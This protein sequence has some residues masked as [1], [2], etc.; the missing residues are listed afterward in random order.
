MVKNLP[1]LQ[2]I[3]LLILIIIGNGLLSFS[4]KAE[5]KNYNQDP[6]KRITVSFNKISLKNAFDEIAKKASVIIIY[7]NSKEITNAVVSISVKNKPI[8][9]VLNELLAPF[10]LSYKVIDDKFVISHDSSKFKSPPSDIKYNLEIPVKGKVVDEQ[11]KPLPGASVKIKQSNNGVVTDKE[12]NF[13]ISNVPESGTLIISFVGYLTSE[14]NYVYDQNGPLTIQLKANAN[15]LN[16]VQVIGYGTTT[17]RLNTGSVST[18]T[19]KEIDEQPVTNVLSALSG[20]MAGVFVQQTN[21]LPGGG[22]SILIRGKGSIAAGTDPLYIIDG[23]PFSSSIIASNNILASGING[24]VSPLNSLNPDDIESISILKDADATAIYGSRGSNGVVLITTKKGKPGK[25]TVNFNITNGI[26]QI[27]NLPVLLNSNQYLQIRQEAYKNDGITPSSDPNDPNYAPDLKVWDTTKS[28]DWRKYLLGRTGHVTDAQGTIS[29][30]NLN[31]NFV[32]GGNFH[33]ETSV[34]PGDN[35]YERGGI[36][37]GLQHT[38]ENHKFY[39]Q[40]STSYNSDKNQLSNITTN[41]T[42]DLLLPP[43]FPLYDATGNYNYYLGWNPLAD[44][45]AIS[46]TNT[47]NLIINSL[48]KYTLAPGLDLK[49]SVGYNKIG[50]NQVMTYPTNSQY[51]GSTNFTNFGN[52]SNENIII[53]P[54][55]EYNKRFGKSLLDLLVGGTYQSSVKESEF[56]QASNFSSDLLLDNISSATTFAISNY[57]IDYKY[58]S[59]FARANYNLDEKYIINLSIRR[60]GSSRF[61]PGNEFGNFGAIGAAWIF[62]S[63]DWFKNTLPFISYGKLRGSYGITGN[64][65]ITDYQYLSTYG[66]S[67]F[68]YQGVAGIQPSRIA[69]AN[70]HWETTKKLEFAVELGFLKDR[71]LLNVNRYQNRTNDQLVS[72]SIPYLTG[73]NTY[74]ANLPAVVENSGW[75]FEVNTKNFNNN[76]FSW[77]TTFNLTIPKNELLSFQNLATSSYANTLVIGEPITRIYGYKFTG[78]DQTGIPLFQTQSNGVSSNPS[79]ATDQFFTLGKGYPN[80]YGGIGNTFTYNKWTLNIFGQF[81]RQFGMGGLTYTPGILTNNFAII[82]NR[83]QNPGDQTNIPKSSN[84]YDYYSAYSLSSANFFNTSYF[85]IKNISLSYSLPSEWLKKN[86]IQQLKIYLQG[87]NLFTFWNKKIPI[88]DPEAGAG[89]NIPPMKTLIAGIQITL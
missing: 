38:S 5:N 4:L 28:T 17:K 54:Q 36:H 45:S 64:D 89:T 84:S 60:D 88:Y 70:F 59:I 47:D 31:T 34:L 9:D 43:D 12:G 20:R 53:E 10:P 71:I 7:S 56:T 87:Q 25:T 41:F 86:K 82:N 67:G 15:S 76:A 14:V 42:G 19:A 58:V 24:A 80:F 46:K 62:S 65:Q 40:F 68:S 50:I 1:I 69:N 66:S 32:V 75:E 6:E 77:T 27:A 49:A 39:I 52:N 57:N 55:I 30:G 11:G 29:G 48:A 72:Y 21:G 85:R 8:G 23:V 16:E 78:L 73:F 13:T 35:L 44:L 83:W 2:I 63:E 74:Q 3:R 79:S 51:Q 18:I 81:V 33:S 37:M 22:I 26:S 61:G